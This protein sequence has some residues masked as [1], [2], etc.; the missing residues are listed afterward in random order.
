LHSRGVFDVLCCHFSQAHNPR[1]IGCAINN[2]G[3]DTNRTGA[4]VEDDVIVGEQIP[5]F[6]YRMLRGRRADSPETV[7]TR[8]GDSDTG[9]VGDF[10]DDG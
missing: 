7:R 4:C 10:G 9:V 2:R 5:D 1:L 3:L 6:F 8:G